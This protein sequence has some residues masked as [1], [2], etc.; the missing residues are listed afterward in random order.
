MK[1]FILSMMVG[2][3]ALIFHPQKSEA[4][5]SVNVNI[6]SQPLWGPVGYNYVEYYYL[7]AIEAYYH[8]PSRKYV[9]SNNG[10]WLFV[11]ALPS[12]FK[13]YDFYSGYS[14]VINKPKPYLNHGNYRSQYAKYKNYKSPKS[15]I[16]RY[17]NDSKYY[18][19]KGHPKHGNKPG[20]NNSSPA[21]K[22]GQYK[23]GKSDNNKKG[24]Q[25]NSRG[26]D[27]RNKYGSQGPRRG[28]R[29]RGN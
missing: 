17:S 9:Y 1:K 15:R 3:A 18:V 8:V 14:V 25:Y 7:P 11:S 26:T 21:N 22:G 28:E 16:I 23:P 12:K 27:D 4:Q 2:L 6:G 5:V 20:S 10:K 29:G 19:I 13:G 24:N